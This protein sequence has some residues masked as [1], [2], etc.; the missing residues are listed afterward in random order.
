MNKLFMEWNSLT[1]NEKTNLIRHTINEEQIKLSHTVINGI[2]FSGFSKVKIDFRLANN[3]TL[4]YADGM[5]ENT[6]FNGESIILNSKYYQDLDDD[7][8]GIKVEGV[9]RHELEHAFQYYI[10]NKSKNPFASKDLKEL[11]DSF[12]ITQSKRINVRI[13]DSEKNIKVVN[14]N[15]HINIMDR[16]A[17]YANVRNISKMFY[18]LNVAERN[19]FNAGFKQK[20]SYARYGIDEPIHDE[21]NIVQRMIE[22][23]KDRYNCHHLVNDEVEQ[24]VDQCFKIIYYNKQPQSDLEKS[25]VYDLS[26]ISALN[27]GSISFEECEL[28]LDDSGHKDIILDG[29]IY[30]TQEDSEVI[31][32]YEYYRYRFM[33]EKFFDMTAQKQI[34]NTELA[35]FVAVEHSELLIPYLKDINAMKKYCIENISDVLKIENAEIGI[36]N[37]FGAE[38][39]NEIKNLNDVFPDIAMNESLFELLIELMK[40]A[41]DEFVQNNKHSGNEEMNDVLNIHD[42]YIEMRDHDDIDLDGL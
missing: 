35:I 42:S 41:P 11:A 7:Y 36:S 12:K 15:L 30:A 1:K 4:N 24:L 29:N 27:N 34:K 13:Y 16:D 25:V 20:L 6:K 14:G 33:P 40:H 17:G 38:F 31:P 21:Q 23:F 39:L 37:L 22:Y 19:A 3:K 9:I 26:L 32:S 18:I 28:L 2:N 8:L 10:V 5:C